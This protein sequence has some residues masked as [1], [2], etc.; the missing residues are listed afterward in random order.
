MPI[1]EY[2]CSSCGFQKEYIQK[3]SDAPLTLA[4]SASRKLSPRCCPPPASS[5]RAAAGTRLISRGFQAQGRNE[6]CRAILLRWRGLCRLN[7]QALFPHRAADLG[8]ARH[9][10][11]GAETSDR[12]HG[13][14]PAVAA[15]TP[16]AG[17]LAGD[18]PAGLGTILTIGVILLTGM[19]TTNIVGQRLIR[20]WE[21][22]LGRIPVVKSIY[23]SVKQVSDTLFSGRAKLFARL[24]WCVTPIPR[25]VAGVS[26][27][28]SKGRGP[29]AQGRVRGRVHSDHA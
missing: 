14:E 10:R 5:S 25:V 12:Q 2:R 21:S 9:Y 1:Y 13:P 24:C 4:P 8:S 16:A 26:D 28:R 18:V 27:R 11:M 17:K 23:Y 3:M 19:L 7:D 6:G 20:F 15:G 29:Q 22:A